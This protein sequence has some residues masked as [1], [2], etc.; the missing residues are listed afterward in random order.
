MEK[1]VNDYPTR[2]SVLKASAL[3]ALACLLGGPRL[4]AAG[5]R[6]PAINIDP[7]LAKNWLARWRK[8]ILGDERDG[9]PDE[10]TDRESAW[11]TRS[12]GFSQL[13]PQ[14]A[15]P[16]NPRPTPSVDDGS[17]S[18]SARGPG[19]STVS[20]SQPSRRCRWLPP[21]LPKRITGR[22][23]MGLRP[24]VPHGRTGPQD[25]SPEGKV[26]PQ[27]RSVHRPGRAGL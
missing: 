7:D 13:S 8:N 19:G 23:A 25:V 15:K 20:S 18:H 1:A 5:G 9:F 26:R 24:A 10:E 21:N 3:S 11:S 6:P 2:R 4:L 16:P 12:T 14:P 22:A 27:G 17:V